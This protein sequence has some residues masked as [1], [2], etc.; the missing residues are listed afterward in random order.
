M[1]AWTAPAIVTSIALPLLYWVARRSEF[2]GLI[3][4][5]YIY[6]VM[7]DILAN[8]VAG[9]NAFA[10]FVFA[11]Y[12]F[13]PLYPFALAVGGGG[14]QAPLTTYLLQSSFLAVA[15]G[16]LTRWYQTLGLP[17]SV[18]LS[19]GLTMLILPV[20]LLCAM[21]VQ[22]ESLYLALSVATL[23]LVSEGRVCT[24]RWLASGVSCGLAI[25]TR[26]AGLALLPALL[27]HSL[28]P[29]Q[30]GR[31]AA[32]VSLALVAP[33]VWWW[34][35]QWWQLESSYLDHAHGVAERSLTA[36]WTGTVVNL[37]ALLAAAPRSFDF[38][39]RPHV[40]MA[41]AIAAGCA[42]GTFVQRLRR[43]QIDAVY[44]AGYTAMILVWPF[45]A[46]ARRFLWVILPIL[47]GY[48]VLCAVSL[49]PRR[50]V[51][52]RGLAAHAMVLL[53]ALLAL[54]TTFDILRELQA[55]ASS[56]S[57]SPA[58]YLTPSRALAYT[59]ARELA[60]VFGLLRRAPTLLPDDA[61]VSSAIPEQVIFLTQRRARHFNEERHDAQGIRQL[62]RECPYVFMVAAEAY[63]P[64]GLPPMY[65]YRLIATDLEVLAVTRANPHDIHSAVLAMLAHYAP[66]KST[67][68][69]R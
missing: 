13:P 50:F 63:P 19:L 40:G 2:N 1:K 8:L 24:R 5:G 53:F 36:Y 61:C 38:M 17:G 31:G 27:V 60:P 68:N 56:E 28:K 67:K 26:T 62:L 66:D 15:L 49:V 45:P 21:D 32:A 43:G 7:A 55:D 47:C 37:D 11:A 52:A 18:A 54:P 22:S 4:D 46:H 23:L 6:L 59:Q 30:L 29:R 42:L 65:P 3:A 69:L 25:L 48:A 9:A 34:L 39:A 20:T 16:L 58:R 33:A 41:L 44:V 51:R 57:R 14:S 35:R 64:D 10:H 12:P